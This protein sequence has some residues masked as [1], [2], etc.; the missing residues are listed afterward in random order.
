MVPMEGW[1]YEVGR[2]INCWVEK[3]HSHKPGMAQGR[4]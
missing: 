2:K 3:P 4:K 1:S